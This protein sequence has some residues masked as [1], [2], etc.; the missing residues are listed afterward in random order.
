MKDQ[1][2]FADDE[3]S[4]PLCAHLLLYPFSE[5]LS[6]RINMNRV[7]DYDTMQFSLA[8]IKSLAAQTF[9]IPPAQISLSYHT[10]D[11]ETALLLDD[12]DLAD[13]LQA[14]ASSKRSKMDISV[15]KAHYETVFVRISLPHKR[16]TRPFHNEFQLL[17]S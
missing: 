6:R 4:S 17:F 1:K 9:R 14:M 8:K 12:D 3:S 11:N 16:K 7:R 13:A 2:L 5:H 15:A 10:E